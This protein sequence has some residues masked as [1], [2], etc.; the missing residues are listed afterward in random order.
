[1]HLSRLHARVCGAVF[2]WKLEFQR[3]LQDLDS[4]RGSL[5]VTPRMAVIRADMLEKL[6]STSPYG[7]VG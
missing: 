2:T 5:T 1:M 7:L 3:R 6:S 4:Y